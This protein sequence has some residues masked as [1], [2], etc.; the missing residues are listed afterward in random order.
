MAA[1]LEQRWEHAL[2]ELQAEE[3]RQAADENSVSCWAIPE[4]LLVALKDVGPRLLGFV[5]WRILYRGQSRR[6]DRLVES[7]RL[8]VVLIA[9][10]SSTAGRAP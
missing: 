10:V 4:D 8:L 5:D 9:L 3:E 1:E 2:R 6:P 7:R